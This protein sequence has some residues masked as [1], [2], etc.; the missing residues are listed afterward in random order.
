MFKDRAR[1]GPGRGAGIR[2]MEC[3]SLRV[4]DIDFQRGQM[5]T[6]DA[7]G[8]RD[9]VTVLPESLVGPLRLHLKRVQALH[10]SDLRTGGGHVSLPFALE[11]K[12][13]RAGLQWAWQF[14]FPSKALCVSPYTGQSVRHHCHPKTLQRAVAQ[15]ART[16]KIPRPVSPHTFRNYSE[17]K[18]M[19]SCVGNALAAGGTEG[20]PRRLNSA[21]SWTSQSLEESH[22]LVVGPEASNLP[23]VWFDLVESGLLDVEVLIEIDLCCLDRLVAATARSGCVRRLPAAQ[24]TALMWCA[25]A[26]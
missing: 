5:I 21:Y 17:S 8:S 26:R 16:A 7:K 12:F 3:L 9:R 6:R 15:A 1:P 4:K 2:L 10:D 20:L 25:P 24:L 22:Q 19:P 18:E 23:L 11:R 13:P 14:V